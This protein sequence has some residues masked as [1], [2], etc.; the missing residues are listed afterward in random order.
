MEKGR[1]LGAETGP[2]APHEPS[3]AT[4]VVGP[5]GEQAGQAT[6]GQFGQGES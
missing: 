2:G 5:M 4:R 3:N 6:K 1:R